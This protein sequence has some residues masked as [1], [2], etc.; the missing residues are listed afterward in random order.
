[1][2]K[3][4]KRKIISYTFLSLAI[5]AFVLG[6]IFFSTNTKPEFK[7]DLPCYDRYGNKMVG[8]VCEGTEFDDTFLLAIPFSI[9]VAVLFSIG[10]LKHPARDWS[11]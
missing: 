8:Q 10:Y 5:I 3:D 7:D 2:K 9:V 1:M 4:T 6:V 11:I